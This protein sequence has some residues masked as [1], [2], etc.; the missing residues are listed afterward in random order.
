MSSQSPNGEGRTSGVRVAAAAGRAAARAAA[1]RA[2]GDKGKDGGKRYFFRRRKVCK[3]CAD[4]IDY[5]DYKDV[6]LLSQFVP[7]RGK[8][9]PRRMFGTCAEH[10]RKLTAGDQARAA[11]R[12]PAVRGGV[13]SP[14]RVGAVMS[15][16]GTRVGAEP[17]RARSRGSA[18]CWAR[19]FVSAL[20]FGAAAP[21]RAAARA[22]ARL[23]RC[24]SRSSGSQAG[25]A[26]AWLAGALAAA[27]V[28]GASA[29][30]A[31]LVFLSAARAPRAAASAEAMA[32]GRGLLRGCAL[33]VLR[34][35]SALI[36]ALCL[37]TVPRASRL[38]CSRAY[39]H[40]LDAGVPGAAAPGR[41][42]PGAA[43]TEWPRFVRQRAAQVL[44]RRVSGVL[45][46]R[47]RG[48]R[49]RER[50]AAARSTC[51]AAIPAGS[52]AASSRAALAR[53]ALARG[54]RARGRC[55]GAAAAAAGRLQR[56][57]GG[58]VLLRAAGP[59][60]GRLLRAPA[61]RR[62]RSCARLVAGA[63][64]GQ[65]V[66]AA[67]PGAPGALRQLV[68]FPQVGRAADRRRIRRAEP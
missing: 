41:A 26:S 5:V 50:G 52:R 9:L 6:K 53:S 18:G 54:L 46:H 1:A 42:A 65:P 11:H 4:K 29:P 23:A 21:A 7:E 22:P 38:G 59:G 34:C 36:V 55:G 35:S 17:E 32:R 63:G 62:R 14:E 20:L 25:A 39:E 56:A 10:Q 13:T 51:C 37:A 16:A 19:G 3:F 68:R 57:A 31:A 2:R 49:A 8:I 43:S 66:G 40:E 12:A 28:A 60:R 27:L 24:R 67:D 47:G 33:G 30:V 48:A 45:R 64:A 61:G 44:G 15:A 58:G